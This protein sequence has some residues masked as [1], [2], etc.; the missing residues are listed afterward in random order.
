MLR[1]PQRLSTHRRPALVRRHSPVQQRTQLRRCVLLHVG[2][3]VR[4]ADRRC[5]HCDSRLPFPMQQGTERVGRVLVLVRQDVRVDVQCGTHWLPLTK[6]ARLRAIA[7][8]SPPSH[9]VPRARQ[10]TRAIRDFSPPGGGR[11]LPPVDFSPGVTRGAGEAM[12][13]AEMAS[14]ESESEPEC[15]MCCGLREPVA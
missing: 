12:L 9:D 13:A 15:G 14:L 11:F 7:V 4:L 1:W 5:G 6:A 8:S 10:P 2:Q 3:P